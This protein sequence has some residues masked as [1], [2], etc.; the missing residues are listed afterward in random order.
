MPN[1]QMLFIFQMVSSQNIYQATHME[2]DHLLPAKDWS[3]F[4]RHTVAG[5]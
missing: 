4:A 2:R 1:T 5:K 3:V